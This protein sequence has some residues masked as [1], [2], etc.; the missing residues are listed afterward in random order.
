MTLMTVKWLTA[1]LIAFITITAGYASLR[2]IRR[3]QH[4]LQIGDAFADGIF[5]GAAVFHLFPDAAHGFRV[6]VSSLSTYLLTI[7]LI[8]GGFCLLFFTERLVIRGEKLPPDSGSHAHACKASA[9]M[10]T[11]ILS[12]HAFIEGIA[13]GVSDT[14]LAVTILFIAI[15]AHKG[16]ESFAL[17]MGLHRGLSKESDSK[18]ILWVFAFVT[19]LGVV[20]ASVIENSLQTVASDI[21]TSVF[22]AFAAGSFLYIGTLHAGHDHFH[23]SR[24]TTHRSYKI[25]ATVAGFLFMGLVAIWA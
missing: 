12:I 17:M 14:T 24:D 5:L 18:A 3:Y 6:Y 19:P 21:L 16:F 25:L 11:G 22:S 20:I 7:L 4:L 15:L 23:P 9:W 10:L 8:V 1:A 2:F 13:L